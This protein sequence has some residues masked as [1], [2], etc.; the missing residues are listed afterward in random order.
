MG[1]VEQKNSQI[2]KAHRS[3]QMGLQKASVG[4]QSNLG[5]SQPWSVEGQ[6]GVAGKHK[7]TEILKDM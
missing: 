2:L 6:S 1:L 5:S 4:D 3:K 7:T